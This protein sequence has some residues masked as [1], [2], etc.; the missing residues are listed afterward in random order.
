M[1]QRLHSRC[2]LPRRKTIFVVH[3][4]MHTLQAV[5]QATVKLLSPI[6]EVFS[7]LCIHLGMGR[8]CIYLSIQPARISSWQGAR[9]EPPNSRLSS[10]IQAVSPMKAHDVAC[11]HLSIHMQFSLLPRI[12]LGSPSPPSFSG[13]DREPCMA[14]SS[15]TDTR[16]PYRRWT[17]IRCQHYESTLP[18]AHMLC[19]GDY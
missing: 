7:H 5:F 4:C 8:Y 17:C 13:C 11:F 2:R 18:W 14:S 15:S 16:M 10:H 9:S 3:A 6:H 19:L 1:Q 12:D